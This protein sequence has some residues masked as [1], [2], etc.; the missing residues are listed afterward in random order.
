M[1]RN[2]SKLE[3]VDDYETASQAFYDV[4]KAFY[5]TNGQGLEDVEIYATLNNT[6]GTVHGFY[7]VSSFEIL[8]FFDKR[9][10]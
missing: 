9:P 6:F 10:M 7:A 3:L 5:H 2:P 8:D 4:A 1:P